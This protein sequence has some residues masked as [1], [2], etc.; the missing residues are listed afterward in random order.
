MNYRHAFHAGNFG[1]VFKHAVLVR[2]LVHLREKALPFRVID[3]Q[4]RPDAFDRHPAVE[5]VVIGEEHLPHAAGPEPA[6]NPV[7]SD[8]LRGIRQ[9]RMHDSSSL[10]SRCSALR[11]LCF[12]AMSGPL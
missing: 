8:P 2:I 10:T 7:G 3:L 4:S 11:K 9:V 12:S 5:A 1:D 6:Q